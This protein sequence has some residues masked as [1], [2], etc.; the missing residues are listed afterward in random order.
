MNQ[1]REVNSFGC[2]VL[3]KPMPYNW[4][5]HHCSN[6]SKLDESCGH[7]SLIM[8]L[9]QSGCRHRNAEFVF[10]GLFLPIPIFSP[11]DPE[12]S[13]VLLLLSTDEK[14]AHWSYKTT[15]AVCSFVPAGNARLKWYKCSACVS[16]LYIAKDLDEYNVERV[17][18]RIKWRQRVHLCMAVAIS[19]ASARVWQIKNWRGLVKHITRSFL[20]HSEGI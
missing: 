4:T 1:Q 10:L 3:P 7:S 11:H 5:E 8:A 15:C 17:W 2:S 9:A 14:E 20:L 13:I 16:S 12:G 18:K 19:D 6:T